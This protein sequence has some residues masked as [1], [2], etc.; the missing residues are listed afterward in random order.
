MS[1]PLVS[2]PPAEPVAAA[3]PAEPLLRLDRIVQSF[4]GRRVLDQVSLT[5]ASG[6]I[7]TLIG[8]NGAGKT[9]LARIVLGLQKP[10]EGDI[11][12]RPGLS[13]GYVP[14]KVSI[15][16]VLPLTVRRLMSLTHR[17]SDAA[18]RAGLEEAGAG[19]LL[20]REVQTLSGGELQ[21]VLLARALVRDPDLLVLDEPTQNVDFTGQADL[22][23]LIARIRDRRGCGVLMIS[24]DLHVVMAA[25]D[26]VICLHHHVCCEGTPELVVEHPS[27]R[28]L[29]GP[30]AAAEL[31]VYRHAHGHGHDLA[32]EVVP[33]ARPHVHGDDCRH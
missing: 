16:P 12:R 30:R 6:E 26:R 23:R 5:V 20:K 9:T 33:L 24:H 25:T 29:F 19:H 21:R 17:C 7:V 32:G 10:D 15:D 14:Q 1:E 28:A 18:A 31:A 11:R 3:A 22:Y 4:A 27:Y 8:P 2:L 13:I